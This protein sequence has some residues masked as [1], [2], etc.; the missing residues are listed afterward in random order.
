MRKL[1]TIV[2]IAL[3]TF[4]LSTTAFAAQTFNDVPAKHWAYDAVATLAK[5]GVIEGYGDGTFRGDKLMN[6]YEFAIATV[7]AIDRFDKADEAQKKLI[8]KLSAEFAAELNRMGARMAKVEAKTST[9][10]VGGDLRF[11]YFANDPKYPNATK[12]GGADTTDWRLRLKF[13]GNINE[14]ATV[15]GR[16]ATNYGN[17]FGN[18]S[19][20]TEPFGST[21]YIDTFNLTSKGFLGLDTFRL[22]RTPLDFIGNGLLGKPLGVDGVTLYK[23]FGDTKFIGF[24]GNIKDSTAVGAIK[25]PNQLT[26]AQ[27]AYDVS[28]DFKMGLGYYWADIPGTSNAATT[29]MLAESG[30]FSTSHGYDLSFKYKFSGLTLLGDFVGTTLSKPVGVAGS[31]KGWAIQLSNGNGPGATA[32]YYQTS[33]LLV[34]PTVRGASAWMVGYR[35]IDPGTIPSGAG[36]FDTVAV[37]YA[38]TPFNTYMHGTDN[39]KALYLVYQTV[40]DKNVVLSFEYQ[41]I[42]VKNRAMTPSLTS[43]S[44]DNTYMVKVDCYF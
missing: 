34:R 2:L 9:W 4:A 32:A 18:N 10:L 7:K 12:L 30:S 8:D 19:V 23:T 37:S 21:V 24:T 31:P 36:G 38:A 27:F 15:Q 33:F 16:L 25:S 14:N 20:A 28:K 42:K 1:W 35:S 26:T 44:L 41:D 6:R 43:N 22:G 13:S 40:M 39:V 17:K 5:A 3:F 11:R 29:G